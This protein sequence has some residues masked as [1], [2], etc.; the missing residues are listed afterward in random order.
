LLVVAGVI[1]LGAS[2][3]LFMLGGGSL[4]AMGVAYIWGA[5]GGRGQLIRIFRA[6]RRSAFA[7]VLAFTLLF[8]IY[9]EALL[10]RLAIYSETLTPGG[11]H[12][13]LQSRMWDY[14]LNNFLGAFNYERW[15]YGY[16]IGTSSLGVQ[17]IANIFHVPPLGVGVEGGFGALVVEMGVGGLI[18]WFIMSFAVLI[19]AWGIVKKLRGSPWFPIGF[20]IFWYAFLLLLPITFGSIVAYE[21]F[22]MNAYLWLLLGILFRLPYIKLSPQFA[23]AT[24]APKPRF[25]FR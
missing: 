18:F 4:T 17:Y 25:Q 9:P 15:P 3:G 13:E 2:R 11:A 1:L 8:L 21:D 6:A 12:S 7:V 24:P 22:V 5:P 16:G 20:A 10:S 19:S 14:P 23:K